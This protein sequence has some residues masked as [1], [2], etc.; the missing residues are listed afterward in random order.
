MNQELEQYLRIY[1]NY[2]Q[3]DW[4][5]WLSLAEFAYN[6][7]EHSAT[8]CSP[9]FVNY[10][11]H[12]NKGTNQDLQVKSQSM[13]ELAKQMRGVHEEV[14]AAISH[15]QRLMKT[16]YD[17]Q[18][19]DSRNYQKGDRVWV[20]GKEITTDRPTKKLD[21]QRYGPFLVEQKIGEAAYLLRLPATLKGIYLVINE[22]QLSPYTAPTSSLQKQPPPPPAVIV[23]GSV[24][25]VW[26]RTD[27]NS[28]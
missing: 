17:K 22:G 18:R 26:S 14:G 19:E 8:K 6:N 11:R 20:N 4:S 3:D 12:L 1:I 10:G 24:G 25:E 5:E 16:Q 27:S 21:D 7:Q 23:K 9:F 28:V 13:I 2:Q 15:A